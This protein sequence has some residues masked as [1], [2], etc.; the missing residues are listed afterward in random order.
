MDLKEILYRSVGRSMAARY[1]VYAVNLFSMMILAR[2]FSPE[3]FGK[4]AAVTVF[5]TFFQLMAEAGLAPAIISARRLEFADRDGIFTVTLLSAAAL[6]LT[7]LFLAPVLVDFYEIQRV[8]EVVPYV[9]VTV[10]FY[11]ASVLPNA[12]MLRQ[13]SFLG[14][15]RVGLAAETISTVLA[16]V[17]VKQIDPLHA[18]AAKGVVSS[19]AQCVLSWKF[20][21]ETD[22][23]RPL[24]GKRIS[25]VKPLMGFAKY[26][27]AFNFLNYFSRNLDNILVG[28]YMGAASL[29]VYDKSYQLMRY[30][31]MLLTFAM[32]PAIQPVIQHHAQDRVKV[33]EIH[34]DF[35]FKLSL[36][37]AA[38]GVAMY[39]LSDWIVLF[40]LGRQWGDVA[41]LIRTLSLAIPVQVVLSTSGSFFQAMNRADLMFRCGA[42][43]AVVTVSSMLAGV[44]ARDTGTLCWALVLAFH[45]NFVQGYL[46][47]YK[48]V[49]G[50]PVIGYFKKMVPAAV[51]VTAL[52]AHHVF[53]S[54]K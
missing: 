19:F 9:A 7:F 23:G 16:L 21:A 22:F 44:L 8:D 1:A 13:Q 6:S 30:P 33:E 12:L 40:L 15:A 20:C 32:T 28:R 35:T 26:Q 25:A 5:L 11:G 49:F 10:F 36:L 52:V 17:L 37:G 3:I 39:S 4:V 50:L 42:F 31:L 43:S 29:G 45:V 48:S 27:L 2:V 51:V 54:A 24:P 47:L 18:L 14:L 41:P 38:V 34:R 46:V 53:Y